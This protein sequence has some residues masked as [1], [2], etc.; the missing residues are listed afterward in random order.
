MNTTF[1][2]GSEIN[3]IDTKL[4]TFLTLLE[5]KSYTKTANK[6]YISQPAVT[7]HIKSLEKE[8]DIILFKN[9]KTFELT[10]AGKILYEYAIE[11]NT[12]NQLLISNLKKQGSNIVNIGLTPLMSS[13][14]ANMDLN[15][16]NIESKYFNFTVLSANDI[17]QKLLSG[18]FDIGIVDSSFDSTS[19][20]NISI[21]SKK[22]ILVA[23]A[24][25]QYKNKERITRDNLLSANLVFPNQ[26]S[27]IYKNVIHYLKNK[28][29]RFNNNIILYSNDVKLML[30]L[31]ELNDAI[32]FIYEDSVKDEL[33]NKKIIKLAL[34]NFSVSQNVYAIYNK[35]NA[36]N[37]EINEVLGI[38]NKYEVK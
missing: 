28:N 8:Y 3:M 12:K 36:M 7:H 33:N 2:K 5:E 16:I 35:I 27:G 15:K 10:K 21:G 37:D 18:D 25:G 17:Q 22:I 4:I 19:F 1:K 6:L 32:G 34:L 9:S 26:D 24:N 20:D 31:L 29:I 14:I 30:K 38:I 23:S 13:V 11:S